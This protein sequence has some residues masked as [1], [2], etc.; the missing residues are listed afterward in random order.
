MQLVEMERSTLKLAQFTQVD[1]VQQVALSTENVASQA[2]LLST[3]SAV[4]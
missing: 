2:K 4:L 3:T 1:L